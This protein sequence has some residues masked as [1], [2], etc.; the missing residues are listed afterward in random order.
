[1]FK[2]MLQ[3]DEQAALKI[4]QAGLYPRGHLPD[5]PVVIRLIALQLLTA[6]EHGNPKLTPLA[7]AALARM[8]RALH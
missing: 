2:I 1:M 6:D 8:E 3:P 7:E 4:V 5:H